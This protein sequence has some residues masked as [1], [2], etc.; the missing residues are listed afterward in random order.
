MSYPARPVL[1][2]KAVR[3]KGCRNGFVLQADGVATKIQEPPPSQVTV[4]QVSAAA[5]PPPAVTPKPPAPPPAVVPPKPPAPPAAAPRPSPPAQPSKPPAPAAPDDDVL[6][7]TPE[8]P[9]PKPR[10]AP[11]PVVPPAPRP[12]AP[13]LEVEDVV[14]LAKKSLA[15]DVVVPPKPMEAAS[16][17]TPKP[18]PAAAPPKSERVAKR[19]TEHLEAARAQMAAQLADIQQKAA[20]SEVAKR[21]ERKSERIAKSGGTATPSSGDAKR[22]ARHA[23]LTGEG[24][25]RHRET[26]L[27]WVWLGAAAAIVLLLMFVFNLSSATREAL[28]RYAAPVEAEQNRYPLLGDVL[29]ARAWLATAKSMGNG[30]LLATDLS[31]ASFGAER[32]IAFEPLAAQLAEL[33]GLRLDENLGLWV[34]PADLDKVRALVA[35]RT[36]VEAAKALIPAKVRHAVH[37][38]VV[39]K[40]ALSDEDTVIVLDLLTGVAPRDGEPI[41]KRILDLGEL[42]DRV[43]VRPFR[44]RRGSMLVDIGRPPYKPVQGAY[45]GVILRF[46]GARWPIGWRVLHLEQVK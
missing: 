6:D 28:Q 9:K 39:Q 16:V 36:G 18:A 29:R 21:E 11:A 27:W 37:S 20:E 40:L 2:G 35:G 10:P 30:P 33:K 4:S 13:A 46:E 41:T 24:E 31:D 14:V 22:S 26:R 32:A 8:P 42:P 19:K 43:V 44:G 1:V 25:R 7:L 5:A 17:Q 45:F 38:Q 3:C 15:D 23:I 34:A 12:A